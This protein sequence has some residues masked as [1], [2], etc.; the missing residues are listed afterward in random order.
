M[1]RMTGGEAL[2]KQLYREGVRVV[3]GLP[4][5]Q[6]YGVMAALREQPGIRFVTTRHE[7]ATSYM[8]DGYARAGGAFGTAL[9]VPGPG[10]LNAAAGLSTAYAASSPVLML[11]GQVPRHQIGK[12]IGVLHEIN[13]QLDAIKPITKWRKRVLEVGDVARAAHEAV[14]QLR[15]GRPRPVELEM[16]PDTMEEE[17]EVEL[18]ESSRAGRA[19]AP[20]AAVDR[21]AELLLAATHPVIYAGGGVHLAGAHEALAAVAEYLQAGVIQSA[22]GKGALSDASELSLGAAMWPQSALKKHFESADVI[23][24]VGSRLA[25]AGPRAEQQVVQLDVDAEEIGRNH[26]KT[27]GLVGD[28]RLTLE[29]LLER[30]RA[31][32][33]PRASRKAE[34]EALRAEIARS[35]TQEPN[36][37][38]VKSLRAGMPEDAIFVAGMTQIGY[39]SRPFWPVYQ[40]RT[41]LT[42]SYSGNLGYEYPTAL[43]AKVACPKRPVVAVCGDGGFMYNSQELATAVQQR[44]NVVAVVFND[45][46]FGNVA[47]DLDEAWGGS[48]GAELHNPDFMKLADAYGVVGMRAKQ[49]TDVG[50]LVHDAIQLDRPVLIEVPVGRMARPPFFSPLRA[51][52]KYKR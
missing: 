11:A 29:R 1:A 30:L 24:V 19:A 18:L 52:A 50:Q 43:G 28:A 37:S 25:L 26:T 39:Y 3:F 15:T 51:P 42:S 35:M 41:Y 14:E 21:A 16:P 13:E 38:I 34:H 45:N 46:A 33:P 6:L 2:V 22:E 12:N 5:V 44:V 23:L 32:G 4:G 9:V 8:A 17:G 20:G 47:R 27:L 40:P 49:P 36:A 31:D 7:Q 10:L 48:Y